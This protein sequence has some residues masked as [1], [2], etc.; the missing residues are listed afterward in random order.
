MSCIRLHVTAE[1]QT[2][3]S[4]VKNILADHLAL[5]NVISDARSV[6]TSIAPRPRR[7]FVLE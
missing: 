6:L 5:S 2:E 4:F 1:G 3:E 7:G